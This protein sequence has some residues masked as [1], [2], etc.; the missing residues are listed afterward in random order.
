MAFPGKQYA[1]PNVYTRTLYENPLQGAIDSLLI[2][3]FIGEGN[4]FLTQTDLEVVRGSS[5]TID[6]RIVGEDM[7]G[8]AVVN[9]SATGV[10]TRGDFN[11]V[12]NRVQ[13]RNIPVVDGSGRG[14]TT[15]SRNDVT[16]TLNGLPVVVVSLDGTTGILTLAQ[17]PKLGISSG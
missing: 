11:G 10:V 2:P 14:A 5:A 9:V 13:V 17:A 4:E 12:L 6:Q 8:R 3:I 7:T 1:P 16:V 15:N